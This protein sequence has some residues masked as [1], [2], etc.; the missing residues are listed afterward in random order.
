VKGGMKQISNSPIL[1][2]ANNYVKKNWGSPFIVTFMLLLISSAI[3]VSSGF[4]SLADNTAIYAFYA[5]VIGVTLQ[6]VCFL[7]YRKKNEEDAI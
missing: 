2:S 1:H 6:L 4:L 7:K 5:L 3:L